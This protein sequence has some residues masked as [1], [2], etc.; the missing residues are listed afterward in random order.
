MDVESFDLTSS[1]DSFSIIS[2]TEWEDTDDLLSG[3]EMVSIQSIPL[4]E[5]IL[6]H[7]N[8]YLDGMGVEEKGARLIQMAMYHLCGETMGQF[9]WEVK[10]NVYGEFSP[11]V[12]ELVNSYNQTIGGSYTSHLG[13]FRYT[14]QLYV[15]F[16]LE[17]GETTSL[18]LGED[19]AKIISER[20]AEMEYNDI[21]SPF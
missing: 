20:I 7:Y 21:A 19:D 9:V 10:D 8:Q 16:T 2:D 18:P 15:Y 12:N 1:C 3:S 13:I 6:Y 14:D 17:D 5:Y 11:E 4:E